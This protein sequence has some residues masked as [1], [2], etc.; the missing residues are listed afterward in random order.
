MSIVITSLDWRRVFFSI[1]DQLFPRTLILYSIRMGGR[2]AASL[3]AYLH[4]VARWEMTE[5]GNSNSD[6]V[7]RSTCPTL[8][9]LME[10]YG[11][12]DLSDLSD[13]GDVMPKMKEQSS[14]AAAS[15]TNENPVQ[16]LWLPLLPSS[17]PFYV[18]LEIP[19]RSVRAHIGHCPPPGTRYKRQTRVKE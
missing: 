4:M 14:V 2:Q 17:S 7:S 11:E 16:S 13:L 12:N 10:A 3:R 18:Q 1:A 8:H 19:A 5:S 6:D 15:A 9:R